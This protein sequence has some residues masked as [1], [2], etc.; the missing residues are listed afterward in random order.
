MDIAVLAPQRP[1]AVAGSALGTKP[2]RSPIYNLYFD[3][4]GVRRL[5]R[6]AKTANDHPRW[7]ALGG[8]I[9]AEEEE[10]TCKAEHDRLYAAWPALVAPLHITDMRARRQSFSWL[11]RLQPIEQA[12]FWAE[13]RAF[14]CKLPVA[15]TACVIHRPGYLARGYG[16]RSGDAK[17]DLCRTAFNILVERAAKFAQM[18]GRRLRAKYEG[19]DRDTDQAI[20]GYFA[21]LKNGLGLGFNAENAAKYGPMDKSALKDT[22]IDLERKDKRSKLM[23]IAD[24]YVY[25]IARGRYGPNFDLHRI[26]I[27]AGRL[28]N[29]QIPVEYIDNT[30]VK[31]SCFDEL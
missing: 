12:R 25:A 18:H 21:L 8:L 30:A 3:D 28:V 20:K 19:S 13:Y 23:Q 26:L 22:L 14:L 7:F 24:S 11:E 9:V 4:T 31:Y 2:A 15:G 27:E 6:L 10:E 17:W 5:D 16:G 1:H 29:A